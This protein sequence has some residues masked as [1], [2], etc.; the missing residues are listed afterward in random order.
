MMCTRNDNETTDT[1]LLLHSRSGDKK[2]KGDTRRKC[3]I[4]CVLKGSKKVRR[5]L[6]IFSRYLL[7]SKLKIKR[8]KK[9]GIIRKSVK[10]V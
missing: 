6:R 10:S 9:A 8:N 1:T 4:L 3:A 5:K 7:L 2:N